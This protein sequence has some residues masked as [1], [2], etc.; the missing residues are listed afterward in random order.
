MPEI[1]L[2]TG[3]SS[4][5][6]SDNIIRR[7]RLISLLNKNADKSLI[8]VH[9]PAGYG[10][11]TVILDFLQSRES[12][13]AWVKVSE[14][15]NHF[16]LFIKYIYNS[17]KKIAGDF[18]SYQGE[19][20]PD[21]N[22]GTHSLKDLTSD[23]INV[24]QNNFHKEFYIVFDDLEILCE[25]Y[26]LIEFMNFFLKNLPSNLHIIIATR[27]LPGMDYTFLKAKRKLFKLGHNDLNFTEEETEALL[28][29]VY[30]FSPVKED[31]KLL[32][33]KL[34]G[35]IT[36][37]HLVINSYGEKYPA[38]LKGLDKLQTDIYE[39][40]ANEYF[41]NLGKELKEFLMIT[42]LPDDFNTGI[43]D[44]LL[45]KISAKKLIDEAFRRN[46][47]IQSELSEENGKYSEIY[48][49][50]TLF[51]EFLNQKITEEKSQ[52]EIQKIYKKLSEYYL[53]KN[54][55]LQAISFG[56][57]AQDHKKIIPVLIKN[58]NLLF[59]KGNYSQLWKSINEIDEKI[60][61][62]NPYLLY[63]KSLLERFYV[64]DP[65]SALK[66]IEK[67]ISLFKKENNEEFYI[68]C[69]ISKSRI[70]LNEGRTSEVIKELN[71]I[72]KRYNKK[73]LKNKNSLTHKDSL[74]KI[75]NHI[76]LAYYL[77]SD[78][79]NAL[80]CLQ[81][82]LDIFDS[83]KIDEKL[84]SGR[85]RAYNLTG[86]IHLIQGQYN[87]AIFNYE[88][89]LNLSTDIRT[90]FSTHCNLVLSYSQ[91]GN[92]T[93]AKD[94]LDEVKKIS[95]EYPATS[96]KINFLVSLQAYY[97]E[98]IKYTETINV[99]EDMIELALKSGQK[100]YLFLGYRLLA[101]CYYYF[102]M[103]AKAKEYYELSEEYSDKNNELEMIELENMKA[104]LRKRTKITPQVKTDLTRAYSYFE[105][106]NYNYNKALSLFHLADLNLKINFPEKAK[107]LISE[108]LMLCKEKEY[109]P[110]LER[111]MLSSRD[112]F[113]FAVRNKIERDF[114]KLISE[115]LFAKTMNIDSGSE[116]GKW[117][118][119]KVE[120]LIDL[121]FNAFGIMEFRVRGKKIAED[122]WGKKK[123]KIVLAYLLLSPNNEITKD[124]LIEIFYPDTPVSSV[125]N[126]FHQTV[127]KLRNLL[128]INNKSENKNS[129]IIY[130]DKILKLDMNYNYFIDAFEFDKHYLKYSLQDLTIE[131]R[132]D[133][134]IKAVDL[135]N[136]E[137]FEGYYETWIEDLRQDYNNKFISICT[138]LV[139]SLKDKRKYDEVIKYSSKLL[140]FD[141]LNE[142]AYLLLIEAYMKKG[143]Q[144][145]ASEIYRT[146]Q[147]R[148]KK[149]LNE[150]PPPDL[151]DSIEKLLGSK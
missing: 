3:I 20:L 52:S 147:T 63:F 130:E 110:F 88:K 80:A 115:N 83:D 132:I 97:F 53:G 2:K 86:N 1:I 91:T 18:K 133:V 118:V 56:I 10:K 26:Q 108:C 122:Q 13:Y 21:E 140:K 142:D 54:N 8:L 64:N 76:A 149:I 11:T 105:K 57:K 95:D 93:K 126:I 68:K 103:F 17:L 104:I 101:D 78:M 75:Y 131:E 127:S 67:A 16:P 99:L 60:L 139:L 120:S 114:I 112:V 7:Q 33:K 151:I 28:R 36:A 136:G 79:E 87:K 29:D 40:L 32:Q 85:S 55:L 113:D 34:G 144:K 69:Y 27:I 100:Y 65:A 129:L 43:A 70:L 37:Y 123:R 61:N 15:M 45:N 41:S 9:S 38:I 35:W 48:F 90:R 74:S 81:R 23:L 125:E 128:L 94:N 14:D 46:L 96:F 6:I 71:S 102:G 117:F 89:V 107:L 137:F 24:I 82:S 72:V 47:F 77:N 25:N 92:Y 119:E 73:D 143:N 30:G 5:K 51:R 138:D 148:Y 42:S 121:K 106:K 58:F 135:Y 66:N 111:E 116:S 145:S 50:H 4:P 146:M 134:M 150:D 109:I 19:I 98:S 59:E 39:L 31:V 124:R 49:Y 84:L 44:H 62:S 12:N 141:D 22:S